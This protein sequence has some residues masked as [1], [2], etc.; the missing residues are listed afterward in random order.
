M[1]EEHVALHQMVRAC[2]EDKYK[3]IRHPKRKP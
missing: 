3:S 1:T 2:I